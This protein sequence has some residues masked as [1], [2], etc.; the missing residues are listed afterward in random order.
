MRLRQQDLADRFGV[1]QSRIARWEAGDRIPL[2]RLVDVAEWLDMPLDEVV[3]LTLDADVQRRLADQTRREDVSDEPV[4]SIATFELDDAIQ[5]VE[6]AELLGLGVVLSNQ[7]CGDA[8]DA[9]YVHWVVEVLPS[10]D[11]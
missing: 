11:F 10:L 2:E 5:M 8:E 3:T 9:L 7:A 1:D 4:V 6:A